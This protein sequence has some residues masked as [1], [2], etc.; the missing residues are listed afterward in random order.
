MPGDAAV[1]S[2]RYTTPEVL[3]GALQSVGYI[4]NASLATA[5]FLALRLNKPLLLEGAPGV[6]KTEAARALAD[7]LGRDLLRLQ[8]YEGIDP[9]A[10]L[11]EWNYQRQLLATR[12]TGV[13]VDLYSDEF[14]IERPLLKALRGGGRHVL[15]IDE[16]D[17]SDYEFEAILLEF[18]SDFQISIPERGTITTPAPPIVVLTSNRTRDLAEALRRR[19]IYHYIDFPDATREM[20]IIE[21]RAPEVAARTARAVARAVRSM[22]GYPLAK[23]PGIAEA[24]DWARGVAALQTAGQPWPAAFRQALG[25]VV[26]DDDDAALLADD[27]DGLIEDATT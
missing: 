18:L 13:E 16:I 19:C 14:L 15:L 21:L 20:A 6:G 10:A 2:G 7:L 3:A 11:Y 5:L 9:A 24:I 23:P 1:I 4:P 8:C 25:L 27:L 12:R 22:R 17:R 26:K